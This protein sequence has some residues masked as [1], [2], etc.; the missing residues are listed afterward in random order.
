MKTRVDARL[1]A[2][3]EELKSRLVAASSSEDLH[4]L[5]RGVELPVQSPP[6]PSNRLKDFLD[7]QR[8]VSEQLV[9]LWRQNL[10]RFDVR[11]RE[12]PSSSLSSPA[13]STSRAT[14]ALRARLRGGRW[15]AE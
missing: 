9:V 10:L 5:F 6:L 13:A 8:K 2:T 7:A 15:D 3:V 12:A 14:S 1:G 11:L 4:F